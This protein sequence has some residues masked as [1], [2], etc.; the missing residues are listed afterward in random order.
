MNARKSLTAN[1]FGI[2]IFLLGFLP[3]MA[4]AQGTFIMG[5][6]VLHPSGFV[7]TVNSCTRNQFKSG[8]GSQ[9]RL[10]EL[11]INLTLV[12]TGLKTFSID[13]VRDFAIELKNRFNPVVDSDGRAAKTPFNVFPS[14]QS[15]LDLYFKVDSDQQTVP[16]LIFSLEDSSVQIFCDPD[17]EKLLQ[18]SEENP[19]STEEAVR[20]GQVLIDGGRFS[21]ADKI[22]RGAVER[23]PG[24]TRLLMQMASIEEANFNRE[25][26][27]FYLQQINTGSI[28]SS[29]EAFAVAKLA[30]AMGFYGLAVAVLEPLESLGRLENE[31]KIM[32]AK[33]YYYENN[34]AAA[35]KLIEPVVLSGQADASAYFTYANL[36]DKQGNTEKA[37]ENWQKAIELSPNYAEAHFNLGVGYFKQQK[38]DKAR[39]YWEKVLLMRPDSD[40][41]R[42]TEEALKA[43]E[44]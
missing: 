11:W 8:L 22:V 19:L 14:T 21:V 42:A 40:T 18:K 17:L 3:P 44:Y 20:L 35:E 28:S 5:E 2:M 31:Q 32:L 41:L 26:A 12:N 29:E 6:D 33:A 34:T 30:I 1:L 4:W 27:A 24:N 25:S 23:D 7:V 9:G 39:E 15:R 37:I 38:M 16:V 43:T 13:P 10:D 36:F